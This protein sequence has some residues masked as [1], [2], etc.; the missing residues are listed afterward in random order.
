MTNIIEA[1]KEA[2]RL[3]LMAVLSYLLTTG[4]LD[5]LLST[6]F[7]TTLNPTVALQV[8]GVLTVGLRSLDKWLHER[9]KDK[10]KEGL[11]GAKG[12]TGF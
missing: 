6:Y 7:G 12:L 5:M 2:A 8:S 9:G 10:G 1:L 3:I 4:V 11:L